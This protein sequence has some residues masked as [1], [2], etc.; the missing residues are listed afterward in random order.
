MGP[1]IHSSATSIFRCTA[2]AGREAM[3]ELPTV[4]YR[5]VTDLLSF[6]CPNGEWVVRTK[7]VQSRGL[8]ES[9]HDCRIRIIL[10]ES[11]CLPDPSSQNEAQLLDG[12]QLSSLSALVS[13]SNGGGAA[14]ERRT[15]LASFRVQAV[16]EELQQACRSSRSSTGTC[17]LC[18]R[19]NLC[20]SDH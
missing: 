19:R 10:K 20:E 7:T 13:M 16:V 4:R 11:S 14:D 12:G 15:K 6:V 17:V 18:A 1:S 2:G 8:D 5:E 9:R 3:P